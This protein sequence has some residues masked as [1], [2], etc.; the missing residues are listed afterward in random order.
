[1]KKAFITGLIALL[2]I[3]VTILLISFALHLFTSPFVEMVC[4]LIAKFKFFNTCL[5]HPVFLHLL[6]SVIIIILLC[7]FTVFLGMIAKWF[8]LRSFLGWVNAGFLKIPILRTVYHTLKDLISS[9][10]S[11]DEK[12]AFKYPV[13]VNFPSPTS[14]AIGF[15]SGSVPPQCQKLFKEEYEA[16]FVPT[17][18]PIT[19]F[20]IF[21]PKKEV[22]KIKM[23]S[24]EAF[25]FALSC[26][27][28]TSDIKKEEEKDDKDSIFSD[29]KK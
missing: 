27:V 17:I 21:V 9:V 3:S 1:M 7:L 24:E 11:L 23:N 16:V 10:L 15:A 2:P 13:M 6:A 14:S 28:I 25:K 12:K 8:L 26:G 18:H 5:A 19:G 22:H 20:L 4:S 29:Q